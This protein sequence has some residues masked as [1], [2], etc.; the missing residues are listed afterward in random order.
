MRQ[1]K[2]LIAITLVAALAGCN[3]EHS[4]T[5][6]S[7][8]MLLGQILASATLASSGVS[9]Q[10]VGALAGEPVAG[11]EVRAMGTGVAAVSDSSGRFALGGLPSTVNLT[12][13][14]GD[15]INASAKVNVSTTPVVTVQLSKTSAVVSASGQ[16]KREIEG[17]IAAVSPMSI[18][19]NDASTHGPV[20]ATIISTT[21][22]RHGNTTI[23]AVDLKVGD[24]VHVKALLNTDGTLIAVE[25]MV[26]NTADTGGGS[27]EQQFEGPITKI[28][29][30]QITVDDAS[31]HGEVSAEITAQTV[32]R[33]G[34][35]TLLWSDLKVGD[36]VHVK[37][38]GTGTDLTA[39][40]IMLQNPA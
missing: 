27:S 24:Q 3:R 32:I 5:G 10:S 23:A 1:H 17:T 37:A 22:I 15:G 2:V 33:K 35:T 18:T 34:N 38:T 8:N 19:V 12:F 36:R 26:Q 14:R 39:T 6:T 21:T 40:E 31:R 9:V 30:S 7:D 28:T 25:I 13:T 16:G 4:I 29:A 20:T 11:V